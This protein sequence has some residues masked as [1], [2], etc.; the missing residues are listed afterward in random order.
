MISLGS[1]LIACCKLAPTLARQI[2]RHN[3]VI[4]PNEYL[5]FTLSESVNLWVYSLQ[6]L[7]KSTNNWWIY[8]RKW[9]WV[10]FFLNTVYN[11]SVCVCVEWDIKNSTELNSKAFDVHLVAYNMPC[12]YMCQFW[13][14]WRWL[15]INVFRLVLCLAAA[16]LT[17]ASET[18]VTQH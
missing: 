5:I 1:R 2:W 12:S 7:F 18:N 17:P 3:Y 13:S 11:K 14:S 8:E 16:S 4:D 9:E 15:L 6:F 10:F